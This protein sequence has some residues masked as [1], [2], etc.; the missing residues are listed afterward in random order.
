MALQ[1]LV[2]GGSFKF[3]KVGDR[4]KGF[5][6]GT[7]VKMILDT[8]AKKKGA[9]KALQIL[10]FQNADGEPFDCVGNW[11]LLQA[12]CTDTEAGENCQVRKAVLNTWVEA[13]YTEEIRR[14]KKRQKL[15]KTY[16]DPK[17]V[18]KQKDVIPF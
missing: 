15:F 6:V 13:E 2:Q 7:T 9:K 10:R 1:E 16:A 18:L 11:S 17:R 4:L 14:G 8:D 12:F 3:D 5:L